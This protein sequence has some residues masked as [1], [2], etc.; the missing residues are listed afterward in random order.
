MQSRSSV[1]IPGPPTLGACGLDMEG[2]QLDDVELSP[3]QCC[4]QSLVV[5]PS[6]L[7]PHP[8]AE[9]AGPAGRVRD[10]GRQLAD[11]DLVHAEWHWRTDHHPEV[12]SDHRQRRAFPHVDGHDQT[13]VP[14]QVAHLCDVLSLRKATDEARH[15]TSCSG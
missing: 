14:G 11:A 7:H 9:R 15:L 2:V 5:V 10:P 13:S 3:A 1:L 8:N 12:I 4:H 6:G